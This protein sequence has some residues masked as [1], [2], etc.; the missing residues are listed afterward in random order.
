MKEPSKMSKNRPTLT[1]SIM[2]FQNTPDE[3][4]T[5]ARWDAPRIRYKNGAGPLNSNTES[6]DTATSSRF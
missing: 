3:D 6:Y 5:S 4:T 1:H 2:K